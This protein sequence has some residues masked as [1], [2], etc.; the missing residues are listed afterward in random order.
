MLLT[1]NYSLETGIRQIDQQHRKLIELINELEIAHENGRNAEA[2]KNVLP[3]LTAYAQFHFK[4][5]ERLMEHL[6]S[7]THKAHHISEHRKFAKEVILIETV[8]CV[9]PTKTV[10]RLLDYLKSWLVNHIMKTDKEL[11]GY[12]LTRGRRIVDKQH[13]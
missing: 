6:T 5:E 4:T 12:I 3:R 13:S 2:L 11:A 1:W 10:V 7:S 8:D 9:E